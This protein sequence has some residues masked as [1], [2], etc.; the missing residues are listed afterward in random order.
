MS[1]KEL[2]QE[3]K[4]EYTVSIIDSDTLFQYRAYIFRPIT[5]FSIGLLLLLVI[6]GGTA[7]FVMFTPAMRPHIPGCVDPELQNR[8][9]VAMGQISELEDQVAKQD[10]FMRMYQ[11]ALGLEQG[12]AFLRPTIDDLPTLPETKEEQPADKPSSKEANTEDDAAEEQAESAPAPIGQRVLSPLSSLKSPLDGVIRDEFDEKRLH[13][14]VD[15]VADK[16][17]LIRSVSSGFVITAGYSEENGHVVG[18]ASP[19]DVISFYK[20]NSRLLVELGQYVTAGD[21]IAVIGNSGENSTGPHL[22]FELWYK[23]RPV[24][25]KDYLSLK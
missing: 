11:R 1:L 16:N 24:N 17:E 9:E 4:K 20:H 10:S 8:L 2:Y 15:I 23:G 13:L 18:V 3:L 21:P 25:P 19:E 5:V 22:H 12:G 7:S 6:I 14:G